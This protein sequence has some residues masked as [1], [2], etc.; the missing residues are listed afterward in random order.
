MLAFYHMLNKGITDTT[1]P[2]HAMSD[3]TA[4]LTLEL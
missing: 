4:S 3:E 1:L 2:L